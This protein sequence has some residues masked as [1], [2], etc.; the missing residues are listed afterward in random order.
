[1][2][3]DRVDLADLVEESVFPIVHPGV[4]RESRERTSGPFRSTPTGIHDCAIV[5]DAV[6][7]L[8]RARALEV[9][10]VFNPRVPDLLEAGMG[11]KGNVGYR[12]EEIRAY[13]QGALMTFV[14]MLRDG[15]AEDP[16]LSVKGCFE[17]FYAGILE[18]GPYFI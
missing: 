17:D 11:V 1:M 10:K 4:S 12:S 13:T 6:S 5:M 15:L 7:V 14:D 3:P 9:L 16:E 2:I 18:K 8:G